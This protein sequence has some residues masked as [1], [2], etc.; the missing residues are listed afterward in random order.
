M[1]SWRCVRVLLT[2]SVFSVHKNPVPCR[3]LC[4]VAHRQCRSSL[5][6]INGSKWAS[7]CRYSTGKGEPEKPR[8]APLGLA[9]ELLAAKVQPEPGKEKAEDGDHESE[10]EK[11]EKAKRT[12][13]L[14][15]ISFGVMMTGMGGVLLWTWGKEAAGICPFL[16]YLLIFFLEIGYSCI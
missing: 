10:R 1:A 2:K 9:D 13:R 15:F 6:I 3:T 4:G 11:R 12:L 7:I 8:E 5:L 14:T 16:A